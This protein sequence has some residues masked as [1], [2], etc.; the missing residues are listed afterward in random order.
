MSLIGKIF[1]NLLKFLFIY[2]RYI[3]ENLCN[4]FEIDKEE[5][6]DNQKFERLTEVIPKL[7]E[8]IHVEKYVP[9]YSFKDFV[10]NHVTKLIIKLIDLINDDYK[11]KSLHYSILL[12]TRCEEKPIRLAVVNVLTNIIEYLKDRYV[13]L[14]NDL[15]PFLNEMLD[16]LD[17]EIEKNCKNI[18]VQLEK[19]SGENI[20]EYI[21]KL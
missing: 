20:R 13:V 16:D 11:W 19:V 21:R 9:G 14:I 4:L 2:F 3:V 1:L 6:I 7:F 5:F 15:L 8:A 18:V 10:S 17:S 12:K